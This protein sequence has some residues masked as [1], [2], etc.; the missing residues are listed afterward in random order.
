VRSRGRVSTS[1][2]RF[3]VFCRIAIERC[4]TR[5]GTEIISLSCVIARPGGGLWIQHHAANW[6]VN[7]F[8]WKLPGL[9]DV[10]CAPIML[11][12]K[13]RISG[14]CKR[15]AEEKER[16]QSMEH[17]SSYLND[18]LAGSV[19]ALELLDRLIDTYQE[20]PLGRF[21][22]EL[23]TEIEADQGTLKKLIAT[24]GEKESAVRKAGA[25]IAEKISR[26]KIPLS[27]TRDGEMGLFL[28]L[29]GLALGI[30]GKRSLWSALAAASEMTPPLRGLDYE[31]L[32]KRALEQ[33]DQVEAK[34]LEVA[35]EV[36]K[37][38]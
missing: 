13:S 35:R 5:E 14:L 32:K 6:I 23:R 11:R 7:L 1:A 3:E 34:R 17:L 9:R 19:S 29:E 33:H 31:T 25:W 26:A 30:Q 28:A 37:L 22:E 2:L 8:Q 18:H 10:L 36:F 20:R 4:F 12:R 27:E 15:N 38:N 16:K 24:L 21:F